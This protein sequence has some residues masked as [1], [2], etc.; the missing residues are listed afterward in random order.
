MVAAPPQGDPPPIHAHTVEVS[1]AVSDAIGGATIFNTR[2]I[3]A[4]SYRG[5]YFG[6]PVAS[7]DRACSPRAVHPEAWALPRHVAP[8]RADHGGAC[9]PATAAFPSD[10]RQAGVAAGVVR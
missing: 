8:C 7:C 1:A 3:D 9:R 6:A 2:V 10:G 4:V 5:A